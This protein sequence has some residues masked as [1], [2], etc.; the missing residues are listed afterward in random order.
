M[1]KYK[2]ICKDCEISFDSW[3][4]SSVEF[5]KLKKKKLLI[6]HFCNSINIKKTL[7]SPSVF[8]SKSDNK[9]VNEDKKYKEI[10]R[11]ITSYKKFIKDNFKYVG[12]NFAY[13]A[14][15]IYYKEKKAIKGI[16]GTATSEEIKELKEE[17]IDSEIIPWVK[18]KNN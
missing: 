6:C 17:G 2:L 12:T 3:F 1:I 5:E 14:R 9:V 8:M 16:Y 13:E 10:K 4:S 18:D 11:K 7:M 15:S